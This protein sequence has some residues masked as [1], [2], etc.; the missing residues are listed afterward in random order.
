MS[1]VRQGDRI[2]INLAHIVLAEWDSSRT[3]LSIHFAVAGPIA[4]PEPH[5]P[6]TQSGH[7]VR[8]FTGQEA[9]DIWSKLA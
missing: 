5:L 3:T 7:Y 6:G 8:A 2:I 4:E 1:F 9:E